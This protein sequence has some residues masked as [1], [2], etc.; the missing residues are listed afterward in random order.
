MEYVNVTLVAFAAGLGTG[1]YLR[2][3]G[4]HGVE[5]DLAN[6]KND[7]LAIKNHFFPATP[8]P[9]ILPVTNVQAPVAVAV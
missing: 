8:A 2:G 4:L 7:I 3:R 5:I 6:I 1:W 9:V